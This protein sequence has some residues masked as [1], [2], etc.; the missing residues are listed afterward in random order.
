MSAGK[1]FTATIRKSAANIRQTKKPGCKTGLFVPCRS[2]VGLARERVGDCSQVRAA[3]ETVH[4]TV[5]Q[6][7][8]HTC[9]RAFRAPLPHYQGI[10]MS[11]SCEP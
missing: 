6:D 8:P 11:N 3:L 9:S 4:R 10:R 7:A 5:S 2:L 1:K